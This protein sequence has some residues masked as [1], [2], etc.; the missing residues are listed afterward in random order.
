MKINLSMRVRLVVIEAKIL[1][2]NLFLFR[3]SEVHQEI[4]VTSV[5]LL[6]IQKNNN[7][8]PFR[9]RNDFFVLFF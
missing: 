5:S 6:Y 2:N 8:T 9:Q 3:L 4:T 1:K 7:Y